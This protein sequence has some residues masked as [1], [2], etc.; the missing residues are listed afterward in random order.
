MRGQDPARRDNTRF[1][2]QGNGRLSPPSGPSIAERN[3]RAGARGS[4]VISVRF[5][6]ADYGLA[7]AGLEI[8]TA[9]FCEM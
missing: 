3:P 1:S 4:K 9:T 7:A 6:S 8:A 5:V 2:A